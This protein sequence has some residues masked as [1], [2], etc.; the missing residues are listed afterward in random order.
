[1]GDEYDETPDTMS[2]SALDVISCGFGAS[3]LLFLVLSVAKTAPSAAQTVQDYIDVEF[4]VSDANAALSLHVQ[5]PSSR[6]MI[7][8][9]LE[10]VDEARGQLVPTAAWSIE[11]EL[12]VVMRAA[13]TY[14]LLGFSLGGQ[15]RA[16]EQNDRASR[17][18][19]VHIRQPESG[20]WRVA[21]RYFH[22]DAEE[23]VAS[24]RI[25]M[26]AVTSATRPWLRTSTVAYGALSD[27]FEVRIP[28]RE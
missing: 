24:V 14:E 11:P 22:G 1:M 19:K 10:L 7:E 23:Y 2:A 13:G 28:V 15:V 6:D 5:P 12:G 18:F 26:L 3:V 21:A 16:I 27:V 17:R 20:T 25:E 4:A 8:I 9:P